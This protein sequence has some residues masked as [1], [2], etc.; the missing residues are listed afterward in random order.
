MNP[1]L[2]FIMMDNAELINFATPGNNVAQGMPRRKLI[3]VVLT[4][5]EFVVQTL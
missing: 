2:S 1:S 3:F 4:E 5:E